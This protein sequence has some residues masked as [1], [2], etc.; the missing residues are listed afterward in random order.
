MRSHLCGHIRLSDV[1]KKVTLA[2]WALKPRKIGSGLA[3]LPLRDSTG[4]IQLVLDVN[5]S[6]LPTDQFERLKSTLIGINPESVVYAEGTVHPR[7]QTAVNTTDQEAGQ[8]EVNITNVKI[9]NNADPLPFSLNAKAV[10]PAEE[11]LLK[12]RYVEMRDKTLQHNL[13]LRSE[14]SHAIRRFLH[15]DLFKSTPEGAREFLVPTRNH[16][17]F[18]ALPQ[19]PQQFKQVLMAGAIDKYYQ[20]ARCFRDESLGADRQ[21]EFTQVDMEMSFIKQADIMGLVERLVKM[22]WKDIL[23]IQLPDFPRMTYSQAM[24][25]YGSDKP[26][27]RYGLCIEELTQLVKGNTDQASNETIEA[28]VVKSGARSLSEKDVEGIR[29]VILQESFPLYGGTVQPRDLMLARLKS[30]NINTWSSKFDFLTSI[31]TSSIN[32][33]LKLAEDDLVVVNRR[34]S[35]LFGGH[36]I[37][38]R[39]RTHLSK[40]LIEKGALSLSSNT[41]NF[42][43]V[44]DFPLFTPTA[45]GEGLESSHNPF[46]APHPD[47]MALLFN[48][49]SMARAQHYDLVLNGNEVAGGSIRAHNPHIQ[50]YIFSRVLGMSDER[51]SRDFGHLL[52]AL[53]HGC[54]PH[55]GIALGFDRLIA[56][57]CRASSIREVIAFPKLAGGDL[58]AGSPSQVDDT[59]LNQYGIKLLK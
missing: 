46:T 7:P 48:N 24:S 26:D 23:N 34:S 39:A 38:G 30:S 51:I 35:G 33:K 13:R 40:K 6:Q 19:S 31:D 50:R 49:P 36:T 59:T 28:L 22:I 29:Q 45:E 47:D 20:I 8:V 41:Y 16:G 56:I 53:R 18:Y 12:Y 37:M 9:L 21:P 1:G 42:L 11:T 25:K 44:V 5:R 4:T 3:F 2:G 52:D 43:W 55:G 57:M 15:A 32:D 54:P 14:T 58:F 10:R 17:F 27:T